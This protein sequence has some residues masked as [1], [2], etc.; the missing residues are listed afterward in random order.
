MPFEPAQSAQSAM[1]MVSSH[2][3][4]ASVEIDGRKLAHTTPVAEPGLARDRHRVRLSLANHTT[5]EQV[6]DLSG[7]ERDAVDV[8]LAGASRLVEIQTAPRD[9]TVF[10]NGQ[11][12]I[13][14]TPVKIEVAADEFYQLQIEKMGYETLTARITPDNTRVMPARLLR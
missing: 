10:F 11:M 1:L 12:T 14:R 8:A 4:G 7:K 13:Q 3:S 5:V 9:A 6:V 2:P